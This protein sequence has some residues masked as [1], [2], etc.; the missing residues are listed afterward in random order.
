MALSWIADHS[1]LISIIAHVA[2]SMGQYQYFPIGNIL[3]CYSLVLI[4][5]WND[6][7]E[8][9]ILFVTIGTVEVNGYYIMVSWRLIQCDII[10][11]YMYFLDCVHSFV[12]YFISKFSTDLFGQVYTI[13]NEHL[14]PKRSNIFICNL[15][16]ELH[17]NSKTFI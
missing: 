1:K 16:I 14:I 9:K 5:L 10:L 15:H 2:S 13:G 7:G 3:L 12:D 17:Q 8:W 11:L 4:Y 6:N